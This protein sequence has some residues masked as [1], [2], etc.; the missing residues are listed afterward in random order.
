MRGLEFVRADT[1]EVSAAAHGMVESIDVVGYV[2]DRHAP[3]G[4]G[5]FFLIRSFSNY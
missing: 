4:V 1:A 3:R 5:A 2:R